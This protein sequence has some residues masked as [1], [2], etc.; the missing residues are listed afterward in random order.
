MSGK[1]E[2]KVGTEKI[3]V[4]E[5]SKHLGAGVSTV[6]GIVVTEKEEKD[7]QNNTTL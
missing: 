6:V 4:E 7:E 2:L 3:D 5:T 1:I